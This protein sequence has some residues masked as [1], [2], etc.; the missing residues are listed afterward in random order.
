MESIP[1][2]ALR[3]V[4]RQNREPISGLWK[5]PGARRSHFRF[6]IKNVR[7]DLFIAF[8]ILF[9]RIEE[10]DILEEDVCITGPSVFILFRHFGICFLLL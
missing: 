9:F 2:V 5:E 10:S 7:N 3:Y 4:S 1:L 8:H 6:I